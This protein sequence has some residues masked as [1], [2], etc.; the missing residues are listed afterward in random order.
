MAII[1]DIVRVASKQGD[2]AAKVITNKVVAEGIEKQAA[3]N[4][5]WKKTGEALNSTGKFAFDLESESDQ[6][7]LTWLNQKNRITKNTDLSTFVDS[8][9]IGKFNAQKAMYEGKQAKAGYTT[10]MQSLDASNPNEG[11]EKIQKNLQQE[12]YWEEQQAKVAAIKGRVSED[13]VTDAAL[14]FQQESKNEFLKHTADYG[15]GF[16]NSELDE[17]FNLNYNPTPTQGTYT[18]EWNNLQKYKAKNASDPRL[19]KLSSASE[20]FEDTAAAEELNA[21]ISSINEG[22][23]FT[24]GLQRTG[25]NLE[26]QINAVRPVTGSFTNSL[27]N[28]VVNPMAFGSEQQAL[29]VKLEANRYAGKTP[30]E[31]RYD[32]YLRKN[33]QYSGSNTERYLSN[34]NSENQWSGTMRA[35]LGTAVGGAALMAALS[36]NRGQQNNAQ[37]YGQQPLY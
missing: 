31:I 17:A 10:R 21:T 15:G 4:P 28:P 36:G 3:K 14:Q 11:I 18:Q 26:A 33:A 20:T 6:K 5:L 13:Q 12:A 22:R 32:K 19:E 9:D 30:D 25:N 34:K 23:F 35:A 2:E 24:S 37:L 8:Y 1:G 7:L 27:T 16:S 29:K